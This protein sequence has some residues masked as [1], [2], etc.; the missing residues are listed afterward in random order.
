[1]KAY[2]VFDY[3]WTCR[4]FQYEVGKTYE[5]KEKPELC[6]AG[7]HACATLEQCFKYYK[8]TTWNK[9]AEVELDGDIVG[10]ENDKYAS[11][12]ITIVREVLTS[13]FF[14]TSSS[15]KSVIPDA[16]VIF[17]RIC[18]ISSELF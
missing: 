13:F 10:N 12:K 9:Y 3:D 11:N 1:M 14:R 5:M 16:F 18:S 15:F 4:G 7:F 8:F 17:S 6:S 2:K